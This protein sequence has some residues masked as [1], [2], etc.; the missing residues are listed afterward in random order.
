MERCVLCI[1]SFIHS[2]LTFHLKIHSKVSL[3]HLIVSKFPY[4]SRWYDKAPSI[5][6]VSSVHI[7]K[8]I[9]WQP[10]KGISDYSVRHWLRRVP[11]L[12]VRSWKVFLCRV[13]W[14]FHLY[15]KT[16]KLKIYYREIEWGRL[17][18]FSLIYANYF[19]PS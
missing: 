15:Y 2:I 12:I 11:Y 13:H 10:Y 1:M 19:S 9:A 18:Y 3:N 7:M 6:S 8:S 4:V 16:A 17:M 14:Y 5:F